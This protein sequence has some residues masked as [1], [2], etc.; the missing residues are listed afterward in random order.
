MNIE[1][2][3]VMIF[4]VQ[5]TNCKLHEIAMNIELKSFFEKLW[6][7]KS[8]EMSLCWFEIGRVSPK[9]KIPMALYKMFKPASHIQ[10][11]L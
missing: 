3:K 7:T 1:F 10:M 6:K 9:Y 4:E 11:W 8:M 2:L 5:I